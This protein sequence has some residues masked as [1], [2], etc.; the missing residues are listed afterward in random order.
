MDLLERTGS[1]IDP[2][3]I[4]ETRLNLDEGIALQTRSGRMVIF[5]RGDFELK[6]SRYGRLK[7]FLTQTGEWNNAR[8]INLDFEDRALVRS[9]RSRLQG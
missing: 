1:E 7:K 6:L 3:G 5:G 8:T 4:A 9:D 2:S